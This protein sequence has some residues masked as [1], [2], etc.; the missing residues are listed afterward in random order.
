MIIKDSVYAAPRKPSW[1]DRFWEHGGGIIL[2]FAASA[3]FW[4]GVSY[5]L[6]SFS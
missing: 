3:A 4:I 2:T 5:W 1:M 6:V